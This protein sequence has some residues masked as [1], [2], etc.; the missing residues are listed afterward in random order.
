MP[1]CWS[2]RRTSTTRQAK[3]DRSGMDRQEA[4][5]ARW[6]AAHPDYVLQ[7]A[8]VDPGVS[9]GRGRHRKRGALSKFI[10]GGRT[11]AVPPGS[12]LVVES[13]SRFT[14]EAERSALETLLRDV[15][16]QGLAV[17]FADGDGAVLTGKLIDKEP[18]RLYGLLGAISQARAEWNERSRRSSGAAVKARQLQDQGQRT[19]GPTPWWIA[20][21]DRGEL[22][23]DQAG[24]MV[25]DPTAAAT[26]HRAV[27]LA[28][29]GM[30]TTLIAATL[31]EEGHRPPPTAN[32]RSQYGP[33]R[34]VWTHGRLS[35]LLRHQ[36]LLGTL[37]RKDAPPIPGYYPAVLTHARWAELRAAMERRD[38]MRGRLRGS[39]QKVHNLFQGLG[40]CACCGG[41][42]SFH[43]ASTRCRDH[44]PG[45]VACREGN[46]RE[47][48]NCSN[49]GYI[50]YDE[51]E[52][53]CLTR[54]GSSDWEALLRRPEDDA[55]RL[56]LEQEVAHLSVE[57]DRLQAQLDAAQIRAEA[58]WL[59]GATETRQATIEGAL[60]KLRATLK[61]VQTDLAGAE[62]QLAIIRATPT[63]SD[64][65][66]E[67]QERVSEFWLGL[68]QASAGERLTFNRWLLSRDPAIQFRVHPGKQIELV[69]GCQ[70]QG[71]EPLEP[72]ARLQAMEDG[73]IDPIIAGSSITSRDADLSFLTPDQRQK[74]EWGTPEER[75]EIDALVAAEF[76]RQAMESYRESLAAR[77]QAG[78]E[79]T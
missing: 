34:G 23:R 71:V 36:S 41:A 14:R 28:I 62:Q 3:D 2:Y 11:G 68:R 47:G 30:G 6:L 31:E 44:H 77:Q 43:K 67:M 61:G 76:N 69:V 64:A 26:I 25:V 78:Q 53:H 15:W 32:R 66:A 79:T 75:L 12:C 63:G 45:F 42:I 49:R 40:R 74:F 1:Q 33:A 8:L 13:M 51:W 50:L 17:A 5:L 22:V 58:A 57:R 20:R 37:I 60:K 70:S 48:G 56:E 18:H 54:L 39:S 59:E 29:N 55:G 19:G 10:D 52:A 38:K 35:F 4:A 65:A 9:A 27:D 72:E 16:G 21:D 46:V 24:G 7:E 73:F